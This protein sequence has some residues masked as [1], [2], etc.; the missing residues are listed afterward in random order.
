MAASRIPIG[1][2]RS[3]APMIW[4][5]SSTESGRAKSA[6]R[7]AVGASE[8]AAYLADGFGGDGIG[9]LAGAVDVAEDGAGYVEGAGGAA[10]FGAFSQ[11]GAPGE[12]V[13]GHGGDVPIVARALPLAPDHV[14]E[15][16]GAV[17]AGGGEGLADACGIDRRDPARVR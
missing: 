11:I 6:W 3:M 16:A 1:V 7:G 13:G 14:V 4:R 10:G 5:I 9:D 2:L 17:G 8:P 15:A 12:W